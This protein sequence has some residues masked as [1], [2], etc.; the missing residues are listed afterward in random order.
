VLKLFP[1]TFSRNDA[2][3]AVSEISG[4]DTSVSTVQ[5]YIEWILHNYSSE[6]ALLGMRNGE[7]LSEDAVYLIAYLR[8]L[9]LHFNT[10]E[11]LKG[12][13]KRKTKNYSLEELVDEYRNHIRSNSGRKN[14]TVGKTDSTNYHQNRGRSNSSGSR[15][16][17]D[18]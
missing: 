1:E 13:L 10:I 16:T 5:R 3:K 8:E 6:A 12:E 18:V 7:F 14:Q 11:G 17:I 9:S 15:R 4:I 2:A